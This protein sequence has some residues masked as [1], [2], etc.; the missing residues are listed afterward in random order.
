LPEGIAFKSELDVGDDI[1]EGRLQVL[2]PAYQGDV[3]P[4]NMICPHRKQLS[5]TVRLLRG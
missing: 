4:L 1:R 5:P 3:V 2:L